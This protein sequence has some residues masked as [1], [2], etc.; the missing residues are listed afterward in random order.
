MI[1]NI[2]VVSFL[3]VDFPKLLPLSPSSI[4]NKP[5]WLVWPLS[6]VSFLKAIVDVARFLQSMF[7][8]RVLKSL[9]LATSWWNGR[10]TTYQ[11]HHKPLRSRWKCWKSQSVTCLLTCKVCLIRDKREG[12]GERVQGGRQLVAGESLLTLCSRVHSHNSHLILTILTI[13]NILIILIKTFI[14]LITNSIPS[15]S[16][17]LIIIIIVLSLV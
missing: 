9:K 5:K 8:L 16:P 4:L 2:L 14:C 3:R 10:T 6:L 13:L 1:E 15:N 17:I 12:G 11:K 7:L